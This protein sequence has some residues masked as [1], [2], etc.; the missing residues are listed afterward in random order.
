MTRQYWANLALCLVLG[1]LAIFFITQAGSSL[2]TRGLFVS[3]PRP[4]PEAEKMLQDVV[5]EGYQIGESL[6]NMWEAD[7]QI[8]NNSGHSVKN[9]IVYCEFLDDTGKYRDREFWKLAETIPAYQQVMISTADRRFVNTGARALN[10]FIT[11]FQLVKK[12]AFTL[13]R[14]ADGGHEQA[15]GSGGSGQP[16]A[17]H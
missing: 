1:A 6:D 7:F 12:P 10:C 4:S 16:P 5:L 11:D 3:D 15:S 14:R 2:T 13:D 17:G 8:L 9:V